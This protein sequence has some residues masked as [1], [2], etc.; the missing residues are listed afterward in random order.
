MTD[1]HTI[2]LEF[3]G[4]SGAIASYLI[5]H[6]GGAALVEC[7]PG[8]TIAN[9]GKGLDRLGYTFADISDVLVTHIHLDHAGAAGW[10]AR[11]G[12]RIHVH[13]AGAPHLLNPEKLLNS[14]A[15]I[16]GELM[17]PLWGEFLSVPEDRLSILEDNQE[18]I[19][20]GLCFRPLDTPGHASHHFAYIYDDICFSGDI[21]G[22]RVGGLKHLRLP[23]PPPEF[24][25]EKWRSSLGRLQRE[26]SGGSFARIAPTHFGIYED[27]GW[28]LKAIADG[29]DEISRWMEQ[30]M[31]QHLDIEDLRST[32]TE[33][34]KEVSLSKG[35]DQEKLNIQEAAN[36]SFMSADGI[37][38]YWHKFRE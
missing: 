37:Q 18:L 13:P 16:Y 10:M 14:A 26:Y 17:E 28:H 5:P 7:G 12:A 38:R 3:Q 21:G 29:L 15:R 24:H 36:P 23:M 25:L 1:I 22:V 30:V 4:L 9:L 11:Q 32:F 6:P 27:A 2:D 34:N 33:W 19:I 8:S 35:L 31:P 20:E